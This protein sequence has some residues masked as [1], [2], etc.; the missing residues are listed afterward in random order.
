MAATMLKQIANRPCGIVFEYIVDIH[1]TWIKQ[2]EQEYK[3][4]GIK[5]MTLNFM[6]YIY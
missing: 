6:T 2:W 1:I 5:V 3:L 4:P